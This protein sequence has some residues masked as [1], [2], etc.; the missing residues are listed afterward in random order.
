M[1]SRFQ[2]GEQL[3]GLVDR[4]VD[5]YN[6]DARTRHIG[7][8]YLPSRRE[9]IEIIHLL[10]E[11]AYPGYY[12]RQNLHQHNVKFHVGELLPKV[13]ERLFEQV[14]QCFAISARWRG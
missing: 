13:G 7:R 8:E 3:P 1:R 9:I 11:L 4:I 5:S 14:Q 12:G 6:A 10:L 2:I